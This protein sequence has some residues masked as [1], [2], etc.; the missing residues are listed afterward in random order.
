MVSQDGT[1]FWAHLAAT[2]A[3]DADGAPVCR[4]VMSDITERKQ[5][6]E[7]L[8][9]SEKKYRSLVENI[10]DIVFTVDIQGLFTY[11]SPVAERI[12]GYTPE[13][14]IGQSF[15]RFI[16]QDDLPMLM[17]RFHMMLAGEVD[18][19]D[20]RIVTKTG[21]VRWVRSS[22]RPVMVDGKASGHSGLDQ[23]HHRAQADRERPIVPAAERLV[24]LGRG[25]LPSRWR[26]TW[27]RPWAWTM[28]A[29]TAWRGTVSPPRR[30]PSTV[31]ASSRT[32]W[33]MP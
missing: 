12:F 19:A 11:M 8:R 31:T 26:A 22:S 17:E 29:S 23:R 13:E 21:D 9:E 30:W 2:A 25:F 3:Q 32:T 14:V 33:P 10:N 18:P 15:S 1:Q 16:F 24:G 6:E 4:V 20:Y 27:P 28:S 5:A 7:A